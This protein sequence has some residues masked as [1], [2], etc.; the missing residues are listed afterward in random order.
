MW[1]ENE[2]RPP[3]QY[4]SSINGNPIH[5]YSRRTAAPSSRRFIKNNR[6]EEIEKLKE[7]L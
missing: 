5:I 1:A 2:P 3:L 7:A 4:E 6:N